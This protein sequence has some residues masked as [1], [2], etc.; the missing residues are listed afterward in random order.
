MTNNF[1]ADA[2]I[3]ANGVVQTRLIELVNVSSGKSKT[4]WDWQVGVGTSS[5]K[6]S[7]GGYPTVVVSVTGLTLMTNYLLN[8]YGYTVYNLDCAANWKW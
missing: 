3:D 2:K 8:N 5:I 1:E 7:A 4:A 6:D